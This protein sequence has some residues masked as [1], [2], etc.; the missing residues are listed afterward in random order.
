MSVPLPATLPRLHSTLP[1][2]I[3]QGALADTNVAPAVT[4]T[5]TRTFTAA[6]TA[7]LSMRAL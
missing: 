7:L 5:T 3:T 4:G 2:T 1:A 6:S